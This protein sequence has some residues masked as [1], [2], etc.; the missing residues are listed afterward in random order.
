M[1]R[2]HGIAA[3]LL[4]ALYLLLMGGATYVLA[5]ST[6]TLSYF[7]DDDDDEPLPAVAADDVPVLPVVSFVSGPI[8]QAL[9]TLVPLPA[10]TLGLVVA[11]QFRLRSPPAL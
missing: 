7:D 4:V 5:D 3:A 11:P 6:W 1:A 2:R 9:E 8:L 10:S